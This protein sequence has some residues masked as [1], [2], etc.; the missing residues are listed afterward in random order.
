MMTIQKNAPGCPY[1]SV[2]QDGRIVCKAISV[3][4]NEVSP[5]L[6]RE[7]PARMIGC[8]QLRFSL[9]KVASQPITVRYV[10]GRMEVLDDQPPR[11]A[12]LR[13]A[14][15]QK[16]A[17]VNS[18]AECAHCLYRCDS[19]AVPVVASATVTS[20]QGKVIPFPRRVAAA[21]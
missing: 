18:P 3:G 1:R 6:C 8:D 20:G 4:D 15:A 11:I 21:S 17:P 19:A 13:A 14:C 12:F 16:I 2:G 7:C 5:N 9:Q 10:T